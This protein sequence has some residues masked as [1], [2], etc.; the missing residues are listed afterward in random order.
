MFGHN[1]NYSHSQCPMT[2]KEYLFNCLPCSLSD[3]FIKVEGAK[4]VSEALKI[5][6]TI[7]S[8]R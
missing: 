2:T 7:T 4:Y 8:I 1:V 5:N 6:Q 3:N